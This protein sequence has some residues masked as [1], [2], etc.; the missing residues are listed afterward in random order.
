MLLKIIGLITIIFTIIIFVI[1]NTSRYFK[2]NNEVNQRDTFLNYGKLSLVPYIVK[3]SADQLN[4]PYTIL[5]HNQINIDRHGKNL[6]FRSYIN[7]IN[8]E[9]GIKLSNHKYRCSL[10]LLN[11]QIPA[12]KPYLI[13]NLKQHDISNIQKNLTISFPVVIK[14]VSG[15]GGRDVFVNINNYQRV[16]QILNYFLKK[17][18][19]NILI[20]D[21]IKGRDY[22]ILCY[23]NQ[24]IDI[25]ER[26]PPYI[27]GHNHL[28]IKQ[29]VRE[30]NKEKIR[31]GLHPIKIN[32]EYLHSLQLNDD[33]QPKPGE[34]IV[35]NPI[36]NF[37]NGGFPTRIPI[38][39]VH[40]DNI[41]M[42]SRVNGVLNLNL[43]GIDFLIPDITKSYLNNQGA[44]NEVNKF[45]NFDIHYYADNKKRLDF[46]KRFLKLYF[47]N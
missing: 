31:Q 11:N 3:K 36:S 42:L 39:K 32:H 45:P 19:L 15:T 30:K 47:D 4:I 16:R 40:P 29:L 35:V 46:C 1:V 44:I 10:V 2:D 23:Q 5:S 26:I 13:N 7:N 25:V 6:G 17:G 37:H 41:K 43:S 21:Y 34:K 28:T 33:Y 12:P 14:P 18:I 38:S 9:E 20:E 27:V 8:S 24:I 22:R